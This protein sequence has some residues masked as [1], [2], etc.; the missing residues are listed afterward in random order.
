MKFEEAPEIITPK[1]RGNM[2]ITKRHLLYLIQFPKIFQ[3]K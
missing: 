3:M 2:G 1:F